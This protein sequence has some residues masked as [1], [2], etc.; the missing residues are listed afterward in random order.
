[1]S[2][3]AEACLRFEAEE[4]PVIRIGLMTSPTL[5]EA[6]QILAGPWHPAFGFLV[7]SQNHLKVIEAD[8]PS[9]GLYSRI[10]ICAPEREIP[11]VRG[12]RNQGIDR[13]EKRTGARVVGV[14]PDDSI[15]KGRVR[16]EKA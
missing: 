12:Y 7:R 8:L 2:W 10:E 3:C 5:L 13:I 4:I 11:L 6:G 9:K 16:I 15:A 14:R 1:M